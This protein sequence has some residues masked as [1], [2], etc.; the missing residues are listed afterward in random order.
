ML[1]GRLCNDSNDGTLKEKQK[2]VDQSS[3][4]QKRRAICKYY[5]IFI[6]EYSD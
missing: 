6:V 2:S 1:D 5:R 3:V 4:T